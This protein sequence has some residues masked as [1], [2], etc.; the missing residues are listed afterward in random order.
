M[1]PVAERGPPVVAD[2]AAAGLSNKHAATVAD[3][4]TNE[5]IDGCEN[6]EIA[7][8]RLRIC[9]RLIDHIKRSMQNA[10]ADAVPEEAGRRGAGN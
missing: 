7:F 4:F 2:N 1:M 6:S 10:G 9:L 8:R 5:P 3:T